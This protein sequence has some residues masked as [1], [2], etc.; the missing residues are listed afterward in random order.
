MSGMGEVMSWLG[1]L[2]R[3]TL[4]LSLWLSIVPAAYAS[5]DPP[6]THH[7]S[8]F[9]LLAAPM[10]ADQAAEAPIAQ[11]E[12]G[13]GSGSG[14]SP[15]PVAGPATFTAPEPP[16]AGVVH[17]RPPARAPPVSGAPSSFHARAP[18]RV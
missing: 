6:E 3:L 16:L 10:L 5:S 4:A 12:Q 14:S 1:R 17:R 2:G 15:D 9:A 11:V 7:A 13:Q 8:S 18:P